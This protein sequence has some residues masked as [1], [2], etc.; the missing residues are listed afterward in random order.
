M[1]RVLSALTGS[2]I[3][4]NLH[5]TSNNDFVHV[6][7]WVGEASS[8]IFLSLYNVIKHSFILVFFLIATW[9]ICS[10]SD[11]GHHPMR[12]IKLVLM[13]TSFVLGVM[14]INMGIRPLP[15]FSWLKRHEIKSQFFLC[16]TLYS[17]FRSLPL[18]LSLSLA[19]RHNEKI[20]K[21]NAKS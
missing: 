13:D 7:R 5:D 3:C 19:K 2:Q 10:A 11:R 18:S 1:W 20:N 4:E 9:H 15:V 6:A 21:S 17:P 8:F 16:Y 14:R 12:E